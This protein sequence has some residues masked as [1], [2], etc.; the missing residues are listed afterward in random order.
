MVD[1]LADLRLAS[2]FILGGA[3]AFG[4]AVPFWKGSPKSPEELTAVSLWLIFLLIFWQLREFRHSCFRFG[5]RGDCCAS[6]YIVHRRGV[7]STYLHLVAASS[8]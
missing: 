1:N 7:S 4:F 6:Q 8:N 5:C 3:S 2:I